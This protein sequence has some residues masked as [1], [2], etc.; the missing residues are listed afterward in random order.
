MSEDGTLPA[1]LE[2]EGVAAVEI[3]KSDIRGSCGDTDERPASPIKMNIL[4][5]PNLPG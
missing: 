4:R 2:A 5:V 1:G 3:R